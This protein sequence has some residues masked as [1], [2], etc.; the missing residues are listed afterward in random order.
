MARVAK[1]KSTE[2]C[3]KNKK[4]IASRLENAFVCHEGQKDCNDFRSHFCM[5]YMYSGTIPA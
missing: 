1:K 5:F 4:A 2:E 3:N